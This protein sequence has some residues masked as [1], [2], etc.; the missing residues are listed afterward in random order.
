MFF[1]RVVQVALFAPLVGFVASQTIPTDIPATELACLLTCASQIGCASTDITC[2]CANAGPLA[3][4]AISNCGATQAQANEVLA[5]YC[6][7]S[8]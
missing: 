4:C 7:T 3:T 6:R 8:P 5:E 2:L 1:R